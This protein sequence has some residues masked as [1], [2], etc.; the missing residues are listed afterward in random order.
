[1]MATVTVTSKSVVKDTKDQKDQFK[2][3]FKE[4]KDTKDRKDRKE[5]KEPWKERK[6]AK[7]RKEYKEPYKERKD[8]K[9]ARELGPEFQG[10][11]GLE[12]QEY[13]YPEPDPYA[14]GATDLEARVRALEEALGIGTVAEPFIAGELRPDLMGGPVYGTTDESLQQRMAAG[15][16]EAKIEFD[17][18]TPQ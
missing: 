14:A 9:D 5:Y 12:G 10:A 16:R 15:D 7:D 13:G 2:E 1:M 6:D 17:T 4:R 18:M 11:G 3:P 8:F